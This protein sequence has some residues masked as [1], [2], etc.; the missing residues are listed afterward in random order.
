MGWKQNIGVGMNMHLRRELYVNRSRL[1]LC[2]AE[3]VRDDVGDVGEV[4]APRGH[5]GLPAGTSLQQGLGAR[6]S[7]GGGSWWVSLV[8][9]KKTM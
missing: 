4:D 2:L 6:N 7:R 3:L 8:V 1:G 9:Q 5:R